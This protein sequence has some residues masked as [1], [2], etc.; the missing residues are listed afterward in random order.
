MKEP[1]SCPPDPPFGSCC[2][3]EAG[4]T[5][6]S[7]QALLKHWDKKKDSLYVLKNLGIAVT[8]RERYL[9]FGEICIHSGVII[10]GP[11]EKYGCSPF[12]FFKLLQTKAV[13][14]RSQWLWFC[15]ERHVCQREKCY[16]RVVFWKQNWFQWKTCIQ[17]NAWKIWLQQIPDFMFQPKINCQADWR[18]NGMKLYCLCCAGRA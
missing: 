1:W 9:R 5:L 2:V 13:S 3:P 15:T 17:Q 18:S 16:K 11:L 14:P 4:T 8:I 12:R 6:Q 10:S 7:L